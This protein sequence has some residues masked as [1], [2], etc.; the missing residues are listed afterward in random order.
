[1]RHSV[2]L[3]A[4]LATPA[5]TGAADNHTVRVSAASTEAVRDWGARVER[6]VSSGELQLRTVREDT[7][8]AGRQHER[9][10]QVYKGLRV[11]GGELVRQTEGPFTLTVFGTFYEGID[12]EVAPRLR[13]ADAERAVTALGATVRDLDATELLVLPLEGRGYRLAYQVRGLLDR[14]RFDVREYFVD[15][16]SGEILLDFTDLQSQVAGIATGVFNDRKKISVRQ[17]GATYVADDRLRPPVITTYDFKGNI[18]KILFLQNASQLQASDLAADADNNWTDGANVDAHVYTGYTYDYYFKRHG[19]RG[20]DNGNAPIFGITH[21]VRREDIFVFPNDQ[22][23]GELYLNAFYYAPGRFMVFGEGL[24]SNLRFQGQAWNYLAGGLDVVAHELSH[25]VTVYSS[26]LIYQGESGALNE[27][28]SDMM[29]TSVEFYFQ[30]PGSGSLQADYL[31]GEDVVTPGGLRSMQNPVAYGDPDHYSI[32]FTGSEDGG[33]VHTNSGIPNHAFYLAIEGG[34]HRLS[35]VAVQGVGAGNREQIERVFYRAFTSFLTPSANFAQARAAT[36][37]A[38]REL[39]GA[40]SAAERAV[41]QA[42]TAV[43]VE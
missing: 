24:P 23:I 27:S 31:L 30:T 36:I 10:A 3:L 33:G 12:L 9:L 40:G 42:W 39:Y 11:F 4:V 35:R 38:A 28:F 5:W 7:M 21:T 14:D 41:T 29:G 32:R 26:N 15:A 34:T 17:S 22:F 1:M 18:L 25:G 6:L 16:G 37:Q 43:G 19:R 8:I 20:L 13:P 2:L